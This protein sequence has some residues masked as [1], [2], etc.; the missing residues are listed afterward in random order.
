M[1]EGGTQLVTCLS[2]RPVLPTEVE[3]LGREGSLGF[4]GSRVGVSTGSAYSVGLGG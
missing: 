3:G 1:G 2:R 4:P